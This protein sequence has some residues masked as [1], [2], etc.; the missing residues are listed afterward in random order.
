MPKTNCNQ[1]YTRQAGFPEF[2]S[3]YKLH[4]GLAC[5]GNQRAAMPKS[6]ER[7]RACLLQ[8]ST[9]SHQL[10]VLKGAMATGRLGTRIDLKLSQHL[11]FRQPE[12][13]TIQHG[14]LI[15]IKQQAQGVPRANRILQRS[16]HRCEARSNA[17]TCRV[18]NDRSSSDPITTHCQAPKAAP[19]TAAAFV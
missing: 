10:P 15:I 12:S 2:S 18:L 4:T 17:R 5:A 1:A 13:P 6:A 14:A 3:A 16:S 19:R 8:P 7:R 11:G 9:N